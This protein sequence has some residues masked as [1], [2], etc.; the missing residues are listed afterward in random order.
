MN[1]CTTLS[2]LAAITFPFFSACQPPQNDVEIP[3]DSPSEDTSTTTITNED[4][5]A[6]KLGVLSI[7]S[8]VSVSERYSPLVEYLETTLEQ[9]FELVSLSQE[10][11]FTKAA[12][13]AIDFTTTN[14]LS[15][16]QV[17]RLYDTEFLVTHS[18]PQT[19]TQFSGLIV[20]EADSDIDSLDDL[21]DKRGSCV[22]FQ[23]AAAGCT[24]QVFHLQQQGIDPYSDFAS[25]TENK[26]QDNIVLGVLNG[27]L[28]FGFI[29][30]GQLEKMVR[31]GLITS[32]DE[33]KVLAPVDDGF[34]YEH[35][36]ALYPEWPI[37]ALPHVDQD[38]KNSVQQALLDI[39]SDH[40]ALSA[41]GIE[42][43]VPAVDYS[44][45]D[46]LIESL[47]L[48]TWDVQPPAAP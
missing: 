19:G 37:A 24:F 22:N 30:T 47:K 36:T 10:T 26:S 38:L 31:K 13:K 21:R 41:I 33:V 27:T 46:Q 12:D 6:I 18:R 23:T 42:A 16:V 4:E 28:D 40:P 3:V 5:E 15:A 32:K 35:T 7:D 34:F 11:Q 45:L 17:R 25:F 9:D 1:R 43:F 44:A 2:I 48:T 20:V 39:P 8:A 14:P 29:R